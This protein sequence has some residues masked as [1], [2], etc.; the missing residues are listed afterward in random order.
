MSLGSVSRFSL[1]L[2]SDNL[3]GLKRLRT[4]DVRGDMERLGLRPQTAQQA[5]VEIRWDLL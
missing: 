4:F 3:M 1:P 5:L 2:S